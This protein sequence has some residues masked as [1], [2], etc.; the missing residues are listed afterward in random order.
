MIFPLDFG[1]HSFRR[2]IDLNLKIDIFAPEV[3]ATKGKI[4]DS[5]LKQKFRFLEIRDS[6]LVT[7]VITVKF[8]NDVR[9]ILSSW[10]ATVLQNEGPEAKCPKCPGLYLRNG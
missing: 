3:S 10:G 8:G 2:K 4:D 6:Q 1:F 9:S 5:S 7:R